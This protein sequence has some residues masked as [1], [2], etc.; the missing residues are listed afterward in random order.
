M[1][2]SE[3][4]WV[5]RVN[6]YFTV[7]TPAGIRNTLHW[8]VK[9]NTVHTGEPNKSEVVKKW[10]CCLALFQASLAVRSN[11]GAFLYNIIIVKLP[12]SL[13]NANSFY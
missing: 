6:T 4:R 7:I 3:N 11:F 1:A 12:M 9:C 13:V 2:S 8:H 10:R 5:E